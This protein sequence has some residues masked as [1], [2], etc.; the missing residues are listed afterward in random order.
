MLFVSFYRII[1]FAWQNFFR[2]FWLAIVTTTIMTM[3]LFV[4]T[5][6]FSLNVVIDHAI[7]TL[8]KQVDVSVYFKQEIDPQVV[9][10]FKDELKKIKGVK[11]VVYIPKDQALEQFKEKYKDNKIIL[12]SLDE[13]SNNPLGDTLIIQAESI[14][15]YNKIL[16][17]L[18]QP[19]LSPYIQDKDFQDYNIIIN[20][21]SDIS[22][23]I[24]NIGLALSVI[25]FIIAVLVS[26]NTIRIAIYTYR[27][28]LKIMRLVGASKFFIEAP[29]LVE[30]VIYAVLATLINIALIFPVLNAIQPFLGSFF[31]EGTLNLSLYFKENFVTIFGLE[32]LGA[33]LVGIVSSWVAV[34]RYINR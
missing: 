31:G 14:D 6:L 4:V 29:F 27:D 26:F 20:K 7:N 3:S 9:I 32:L 30:G 33:M 34:R 16:N 25:F 1:K 10:D 23:T 18:S 19:E 13:L 8:H 12:E 28:E 22:R 21:I 5:V 24:N 15:D 17:I 11:E 2:N